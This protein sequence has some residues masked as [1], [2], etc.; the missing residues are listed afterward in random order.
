VIVPGLR[1]FVEAV[2]RYG[3]PNFVASLVIPKSVRAQ[4]KLRQSMNALYED[5][6]ISSSI[7]D[8]EEE[9]SAEL[10]GLGGSADNVYPYVYVPISLD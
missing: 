9:E 10:K 5:L 3:V 6:S 4:E 2:L 7:A 8:D 1:V